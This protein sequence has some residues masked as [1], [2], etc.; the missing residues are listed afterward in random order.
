METPKM[1]SFRKDNSSELLEESLIIKSKKID[2]PKRSELKFP[3]E[4]GE[5]I[6]PECK[7]YVFNSKKLFIFRN[8]YFVNVKTLPNGL[9]LLKDIS[10]FGKKV[11]EDNLNLITHFEH[12]DKSTLC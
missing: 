12:F 6:D 8:P 11:I 5:L 7:E 4:K 3:K 1:N 9:S 10:D 2:E